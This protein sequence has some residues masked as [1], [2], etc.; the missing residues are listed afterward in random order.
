MHNENDGITLLYTNL[1]MIFQFRS[2]AY[3]YIAFRNV[4]LPIVFFEN[5]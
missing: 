4:A 2:P 3:D 5:S 1:V